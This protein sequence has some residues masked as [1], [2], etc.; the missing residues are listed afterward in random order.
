MSKKLAALGLAWLALPGVLSLFDGN[1][2]PC[3]SIDVLQ[4]DYV[5]TS[6]DLKRF[7]GTYYELGYKDATQPRMCN[8]IRT[9]KTLDHVD[10]QVHD[11]F[12]LKCAGSFY[13]NDLVFN[14]TNTKGYFTSQWKGVPLLDL[15]PFTDVV[16]DVGFPSSGDDGVS[17]YRWVLEFQCIPRDNNTGNWFFAMNYYSQGIDDQVAL[18]EMDAAARAHGLAP[19]LDVG[20][21]L[22][23]VNQTDCNYPAPN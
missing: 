5:K 8:C 12:I 19:F 7:V 6:F 11:D 13:P 17:Q 9:T 23:I 18:E 1:N 21:K 14:I 2:L 22:Q 20:N 4:S 3:P 16:L 10:N 15:I